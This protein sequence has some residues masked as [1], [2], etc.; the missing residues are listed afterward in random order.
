[1]K[2]RCPAAAA[3]LKPPSGVN[4]DEDCLTLNV[5]RPKSHRDGKKIP[6]AVYI[7]GGAFNRGTCE[8][9]YISQ[10]N[11][12]F[13]MLN[14]F[15]CSSDAQHCIYGRVVRIAF[16]GHYIQLQVRLLVCIAL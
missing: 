10:F 7:H 8:L 6:V 11:R 2:F 16:L 1:M 15:S 3:V 5:F 12:V 9:I 13:T 4:E 14:A